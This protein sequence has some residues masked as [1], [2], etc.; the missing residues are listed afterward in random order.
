MMLGRGHG[1]GMVSVDAMHPS[2]LHTPFPTPTATGQYD[3]VQND[4]FLPFG[5]PSPGRTGIPPPPGVRLGGAHVQQAASEVAQKGLELQEAQQRLLQEQA[6]SFGDNFRSLAQDVAAMKLSHDA[7]Q[8]DMH[9]KIDAHVRD[10]RASTHRLEQMVQTVNAAQESGNTKVEQL[11]ERLSASGPN[12]VLV[13]IQRDIDHT[14]M[15]TES[16]RAALTKRLDHLE[17]ILADSSNKHHERTKS[18]EVQLTGQIKAHVAQHASSMQRVDHLD[19]LLHGLKNSHAN[20]VSDHHEARVAHGAALEDLKKSHASFSNELGSSAAR[21]AEFDS[22]LKSVEQLATNAANGHAKQLLAAHQQVQDCHTQVAEEAA[23]RGRLQ[24]SILDRLDKLDAFANS[25]ADE[26]HARWQAVHKGLQDLHGQLTAGLGGR[27][28]AHASIE[29]RI[30]QVELGS[31]DHSGKVNDLVRRLS[32]ERDENAKR[33]SANAEQLRSLDLHIKD[34]VGTQ[35]QQVRD[36]VLGE[37]EARDAQNATV[38]R[39]LKHMEMTVADSVSEHTNQ[40]QII[41]Q[42]VQS[43]Q[44][45]VADS[46]KGQ[47]TLL[48]SRGDDHRLYPDSAKGWSADDC[49]KYVESMPAAAPRLDAAAAP[50]HSPGGNVSGD[51]D[52]FRNAQKIVMQDDI[53]VATPPQIF[54]LYQQ[55]RTFSPPKPYSLGRVGSLPSLR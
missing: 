39:R 17:S 46:T 22:K 53:R 11:H 48:P 41:R 38:D 33:H 25:A 40:L 36:H 20:A 44:A 42:K 5:S 26:H 1:V 54:Q 52:F 18:L 12:S 9:S 2:G 23:A 49:L 3:E 30:K 51:R 29:E 34:T 7:L 28:A 24:V 27:M 43:L 55:P 8:A 6:A 37:R 16:S 21:H 31:G 32:Q 45:S 13:D 19:A 35:L 10:T 50:V 14:R 4:G 15:H 47:E